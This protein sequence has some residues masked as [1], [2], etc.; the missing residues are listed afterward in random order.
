M[1][2]SDLDDLL[3]LAAMRPP[4]ASPALMDRVLADALAL[5]PQPLTAPPPRAGAVARP[6]RLSRLAEMLGGPAV[7]AGVA[8]AALFG[9]A[10]GYLDPTTMDILAPGQATD[11]AE[12][13]AVDLFPEVDFL[14]TEG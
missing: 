13:E 3:A 9:V 5:Q 12:A 10:L 7:L 6:G 2:T 14:M 1:Q 11:Q 4:A 8:S